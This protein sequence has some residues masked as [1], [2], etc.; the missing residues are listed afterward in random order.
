MPSQE[1]KLCTEFF[2][3]LEIEYFMH[4]LRIL[5]HQFMAGRRVR[6]IDRYDGI[7]FVHILPLSLLYRWSYVFT[8]LTL[9]IGHRQNCIESGFYREAC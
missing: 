5:L 7:V 4:M 3:I 8:V 1:H 9:L 2:L 6:G